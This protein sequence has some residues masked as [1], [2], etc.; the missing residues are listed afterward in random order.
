[1]R[2]ATAIKMFGTATALADVLGVSKQSLTV[3]QEVLTTRQTDQVIGA[4]LRT[5]IPIE[6]IG[7]ALTEPA[8]PY[9]HGSKDVR[10][11]Q[12]QPHS[13]AC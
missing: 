1:M 9:R 3:W 10:R 5:R 8:I 11:R 7:A 13:A 12:D 4:A 2:K 6:Q